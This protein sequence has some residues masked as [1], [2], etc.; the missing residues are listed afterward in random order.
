MYVHLSP[1]CQK[2]NL[3]PE[4]G[5]VDITVGITKGCDLTLTC[6]GFVLRRLWSIWKTNRNV[7]EKHTLITLGSTSTYQSKPSI[8]KG[9]IW[10]NNPSN[11]STSKEN[12]EWHFQKKLL[13]T[14]TSR[15]DQK[16]LDWEEAVDQNQAKLQ[17]LRGSERNT[18]QLQ[19]DYNA[20]Q[21]IR[22]T[23]TR[24]PADLDPAELRGWRRLVRRRARLMSNWISQ[25]MW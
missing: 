19:G 6:C 4:N 17:G 9:T 1:K 24:S 18:N 15:L 21:V 20:T 13:Q 16:T 5:N 8:S 14:A 3:W 2:L 11:N 22:C 23:W 25:L 12:A 7:P 10:V